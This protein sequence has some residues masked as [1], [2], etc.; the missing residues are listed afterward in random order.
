MHLTKKF[1]NILQSTKKLPVSLRIGNYSTRR[2]N[3]ICSNDSTTKYKGLI[4]G[5]YEKEIP[6]DPPKLTFYGEQFDSQ[7]NGKIAKFIDKYDMTGKLYENKLFSDVHDEYRSVVV[8]GL[9]KEAAGYCEIECIDDDRENVR[10]ASAIGA[11]KLDEHRCTEIYVDPMEYPE[12]AAEG[13]SLS[14][15][16]YQDNVTKRKKFE[17]KLKLFESTDYDQWN[18]G[19]I[20]AQAQNHARRLNEMP[21]NQLTPLNF[22][23]ETVDYL[24]PCGINVEVR[25]HEWIEAQ[26]M[27]ALDAV[28]KSSCELP[29]FLEIKYCG[30]SPEE[31]PIVLIG[32]GLTFNTGGI[33]LKNAD[34]FSENRASMAGAATVVSVIRAASSLKLPINI[35]GLIPVCENMISGLVARPGDIVKCS[36][37]KTIAVHDTA[38]AGVLLL[39]DALIYA[40]NNCKPKLI[41]D[42]ATLSTDMKNSLGGAASGIFTVSQYLW[43]EI[44]KA[45]TVTGDRVWRMP[46]WNYFSEKVTRYPKFD[47]SNRGFGSAGTCKSAAILREFI[48]CMDWIHID[49]LGV[50]MLSHNN[51]LPYLKEGTMTGRP[52]R[53]L[54]QF[55]NQLAHPEP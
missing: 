4:I 48:P 53:L 5:I 36:N 15:W 47:V 12:Q 33:C 27:T 10:I 17:P 51:I 22:A 24:C 29:V 41:I 6:T 38:E 23:Q 25:T 20:N 9:G 16:K 45:G 19:L 55:L 13:S 11:Q 49:M 44:F 43:H 26:K 3:E 7:M 21:A 37:G 8:V 34:G 46:L 18:R 1:Y 28:A 31:K 40:Q 39:A 32:Q 35:T 2:N 30:T 14:I 54:I 50:G 42:V 52:T